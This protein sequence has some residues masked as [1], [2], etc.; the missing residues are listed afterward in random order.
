[1]RRQF[2][3]TP[4]FLTPEA[5]LEVILTQYESGRLGLQFMGRRVSY[6][7]VK[8]LLEEALTRISHEL[9]QGRSGRELFP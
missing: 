6:L 9:D 1:M 8:H 5:T 4:S 3:Q 2:R 7:A